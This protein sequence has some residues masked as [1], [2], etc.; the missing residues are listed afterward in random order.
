MPLFRESKLFL[1]GSN[2]V[3]CGFAGGLHRRRAGGGKG[4]HAD[5]LRLIL[6]G[7]FHKS[8]RRNVR[9]EIDHLEAGP[10]SMVPIVFPINR[11]P[12]ML[13]GMLLTSM[14]DG[15]C[16][17]IMIDTASSLCDSPIP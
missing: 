7:R 17:G 12:G 9:S 2:N 11:G 1:K 10:L 8:F 13:H 14:K 15:S 5:E 16:K 4:R 3:K 6:P